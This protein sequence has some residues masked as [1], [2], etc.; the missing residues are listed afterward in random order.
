[1]WTHTEERKK[2][3]LGHYV[4]PVDFN[5]D[6]I[7]EVLVGSLL[8]DSKGKMIWNRFDLLY[9]NHDH[10]DSYKFGDVNGD[11]NNDIVTAN[12][13]TGVFVYEAMTGH[14]L[15][16]N[17]AEHS[18]QIQVGNFLKGMDN[19]QIVVGGRTYGNRQIGEPYLSSQLF[20]FSRTGEKLFRWPDTPINGNPDFV[21]GDWSG[22]G[23]EQ[24]FWFKFRINDA[25]KG[26]FYFPDPVYHMF[27]F[28][29]TG[30]EQ[31]ITLTRGRLSVYGSKKAAQKKNDR[32][33]DLGYLKTTVVNHTHY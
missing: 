8:L 29:G 20:W 15:W 11:G 26:I 22:D 3:N 10:A 13:E 21:K 30:A 33:K 25:G 28:M 1:M 12:S 14:I 5:K 27:D 2:D 4:Y 6:G 31:V 24:L 17:T 7:D 16:Q 19:P 32:K 23:T 9:D 18:Q